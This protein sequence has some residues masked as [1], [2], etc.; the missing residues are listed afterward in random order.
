MVAEGQLR[1]WVDSGYIPPDYR[2]QTFMV[3]EARPSWNGSWWILMSGEMIWEVDDI[4]EHYS[5]PM[6]DL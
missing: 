5:D 1:Q 3:V 6:V 2:L 4:I